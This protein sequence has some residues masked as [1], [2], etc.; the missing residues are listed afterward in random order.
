[1][2]GTPLAAQSRIAAERATLFGVVRV[3]YIY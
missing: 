3:L 2:L 1:V